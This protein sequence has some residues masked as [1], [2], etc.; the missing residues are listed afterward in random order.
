MKNKT[1]ERKYPTGNPPRE[2][3]GEPSQADY[4]NTAALQVI[5]HFSMLVQ[6]LRVPQ[7]GLRP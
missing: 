2:A 1:R 5:L 4:S 3:L 7:S 6:E